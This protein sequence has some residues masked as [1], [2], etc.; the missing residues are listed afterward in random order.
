M[1]DFLRNVGDYVE[2]ETTGGFT[3]LDPTQIAGVTYNRESSEFS[4]HMKSGTI[5]TAK[6]TKENVRAIEDFIARMGL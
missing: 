4:I 5:F 1:R 2:L 3:R 6:G